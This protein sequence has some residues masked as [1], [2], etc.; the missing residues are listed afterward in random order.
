MTSKQNI[1]RRKIPQ[2]IIDILIN[3]LLDPIEIST[4]ETKR[5]DQK[6]L[7]QEKKSQVHDN[8]SMFFKLK[9][10]FLTI[11]RKKNCVGHF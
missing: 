9:S 8:F 4:H 2:F 10:V 11:V 5:C 1:A 7:T 6:K 3:L